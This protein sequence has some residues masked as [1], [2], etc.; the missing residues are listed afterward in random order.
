MARTN[1]KP[2][3]CAKGAQ[4]PC[5][6][7]TGREPSLANFMQLAERMADAMEGQQAQFDRKVCSELRDIS[8]DITEMRREI[9]RLRACELSDRHLP[10]ASEDLGATLEATSTA[11]N[12]IMECVETILQADRENSDEFAVLVIDQVVQI[13]EACTFHDITG[14]RVTRLTETLRDVEDR[15]GQF[16]TAVGTRAE[17]QP[18]SAEFMAREER[19]ARLLLNGPQSAGKAISQNAADD[20]MSA[21]EVEAASQDDIDSLFD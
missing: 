13:L 3:L 17:A 14:Q 18:R 7:R 1:Q 4:S 12:S 11:T 2:H 16:A 5:R 8:A 20:I 15:L 19:R 10:E 6:N 9:E 21:A